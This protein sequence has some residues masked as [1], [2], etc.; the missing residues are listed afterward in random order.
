[1]RANDWFLDCRPCNRMFR[2]PPGTHLITGE[3]W[4]DI[5]IIWENFMTSGIGVHFVCADVDA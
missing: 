3:G 5:D 2:D 4:S 1:M